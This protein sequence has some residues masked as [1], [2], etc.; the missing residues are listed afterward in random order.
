ML[1]EDNKKKISKGLQMVVVLLVFA[2][3]IV[4]VTLFRL[5]SKKEQLEA[6]FSDTELQQSEMV[7]EIEIFLPETIYAVAGIPLELYNGQVTGLGTDITTFN[8]LWNCEIGENLERRF[9]VFPQETDLGEHELVFEIYN[10]QLELVAR[11]ECILKVVEE[12]PNQKDAAV[13]VTKLSEV[14]SNCKMQVVC[15]VDTAYNGSL[16]EL[17]PEGIRQLQDVIYAVLS[18]ME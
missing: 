7:E 11:K 3:V 16:E 4:S 10:N 2:I 15:S 1:M 9:Y 13:T 18:G 14:P 12:N 5:N 6:Q 8:V 17:K